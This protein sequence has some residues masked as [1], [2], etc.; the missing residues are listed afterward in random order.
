MYSI[1]IFCCER[2]ATELT[3]LQMFR[4]CA[5]RITEPE[6]LEITIKPTNQEAKSPTY[7]SLM[8]LA[9]NGGKV[10]EHA[11]ERLRELM[12]DAGLN[13]EK[14]TFIDSLKSYAL[15]GVAP[16]PMA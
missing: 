1:E 15:G 14:D 2:F 13:K 5:E 16:S 8:V 9:H 11:R 4:T 10:L 7:G 3:M 6:S 12:D